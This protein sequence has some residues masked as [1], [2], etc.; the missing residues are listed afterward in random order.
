M[1][2][3]IKNDGSSIIN[4]LVISYKVY[5]R[6]DQ[7][8][9]N[10]FNFS[11]SYDDVNYTALPAYNYTTH[12][13]FDLAGWVLGASMNDSISGLNIPPTTMFIFAGQV[14]M[15]PDPVVGTR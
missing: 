1:T 13:A 5:Q 15:F 8:R 7:N 10:S 3:R 6:N 2:L 11:Y 4:K 14:M 12:G 9:S